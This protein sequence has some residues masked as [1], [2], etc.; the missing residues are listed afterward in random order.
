MIQSLGFRILEGAHLILLIMLGETTLAMEIS[1]RALT[2][3]CTSTACGT[4]S[5]RRARHVCE[6]ALTDE[7]LNQALSAFERVGPRLN[8]I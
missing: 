1:Q 6:R 2:K 7:H 4:P 8:L 3:G 5:F